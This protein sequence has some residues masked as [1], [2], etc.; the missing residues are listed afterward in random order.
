[1]T[2]DL[3]T[4]PLPDAIA[5]TRVR[6]SVNGFD[7]WLGRTG[8]GSG[9]EHLKWIRRDAL[10]DV[11]H[12]AQFVVVHVAEI[13]VDPVDPGDRRDRLDDSPA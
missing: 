8:C 3:P 2:D 4:P 12:G 11:G 5:S 10:Q 1:M 9:I 6:L 7:A 13:D